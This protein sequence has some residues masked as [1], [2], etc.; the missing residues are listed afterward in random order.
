MC[1]MHMCVIYTCVCHTHVCAIHTCLL[2]ACV[3]YAHVCAIHMYVCYTDE[4]MG[5]YVCY[6]H[7]NILS[8][9]T[10]GNHTTHTMIYILYSCDCSVLGRCVCVGKQACVLHCVMVVCLVGDVCICV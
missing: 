9:P 2:C 3:C 8:Y 5:V 10:H 7:A 4:Y 6:V 1:G